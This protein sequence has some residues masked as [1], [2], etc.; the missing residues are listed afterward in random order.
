MIY[1]NYTTINVV[2]Y[3]GKFIFY[4]SLDGIYVDT[5][6]YKKVYKY[7]IE[8]FQTPREQ[9]RTNQRMNIIRE[10]LMMRCM[11]PSRLERWIETGGDV[12]DF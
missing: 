5:T 10:E 11:H 1:I 3:D 7:D 6:P 2:I 9:Y 4:L 12:D 8:H